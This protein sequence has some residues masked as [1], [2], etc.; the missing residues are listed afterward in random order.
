MVGYPGVQE[1]T[2]LLTDPTV[3]ACLKHLTTCY[4]VDIRLHDLR[5]E[6]CDSVKFAAF[7]YKAM[8]KR[9]WSRQ[10]LW[11]YHIRGLSP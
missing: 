7:N 6:C 3:H 11:Y 1:A 2:R 9:Q 4:I 5:V 8:S 10:R